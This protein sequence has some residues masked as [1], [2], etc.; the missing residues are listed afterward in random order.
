MGVKLWPCQMTMDLM[1]LTLDDLI[2]GLDD[3]AGAGSAV[4]LMKQ[5]SIS[6]FI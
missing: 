6:L 4:S 2:D 3:P 5:A 1:G